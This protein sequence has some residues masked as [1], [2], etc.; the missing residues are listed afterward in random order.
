MKKVLL[1]LVVMVALT[2]VATLTAEK[3]SALSLVN[4]SASAT[5]SRPS[6]SSPLSG[7]YAAGVSTVTVVNNSS[8]F[9]ASDSA[10]F[11]RHGTQE[12]VTVATTSAN[13]LSVFFTDNTTAAHNATGILAVPISAMHTVVFTTQTAIPIGGQIVIAYPAAVASDTVQA[14]PSATTWMFNGLANANIKQKFSQGAATCGANWV[15]SGVTNGTGV[16]TPTATC[17]V[18]GATIP[19]GTTVWVWL[20]CSASAATTCTTQVPQIINPTH[21]P[22]T[23]RG[24]ADVKN[25][26][27]TTLSSSGGTILDQATL[28]MGTIESVFVVAHVDPTFTF[29]IDGVPASTDMDSSGTFCGTAYADSVITNSSFPSTPTEVNLGVINAAANYYA[30]QKMTITS[31]TAAGY[32]ITATS[33]GFLINPATGIYIPNAQG[34]V[35]GND[36]PAPAALPASP[37]SGA[38]GINSCDSN[39]RVNT[40]IWGQATP[41]FA[42]PSPSYYYTLVN[43][44]GSLETNGDILY[45]VYG[46]RAATNTPPGDYWQII[47]YTAS[48]T[49]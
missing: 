27:L 10:V 12:Y 33:S 1:L 40:T 31:N 11:M 46:A 44:S 17:T 13:K 19:A 9:L 41:N 45:V 26:A 7:A 35:L 6:P 48:V 43:Y 38:Y 4:A 39:S 14:S 34:N 20:G 25:I 29:I 47:S 2:V 42:N 3:A 8:T 16:Q 37:G 21:N 30:A 5:T 23:A 49:F 24:T 15:L 28:K 18:A 36:D 32:A 22:S